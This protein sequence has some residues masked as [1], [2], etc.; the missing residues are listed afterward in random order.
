MVPRVNRVLLEPRVREARRVKRVI[1]VRKVTLAYK[2]FRDKLALLEK[3]V[4]L[5]LKALKGR[6]VL[7]V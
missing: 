4:W 3:E 7:M 2:A 6:G 1:L 5:V